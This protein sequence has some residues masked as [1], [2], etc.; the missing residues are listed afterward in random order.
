MGRFTN[1]SPPV[2]KIFTANT[3]QQQ[4][5]L[6][7]WIGAR[8]VNNFQDYYCGFLVHPQTSC[9]ASCI[10]N[11]QLRKDVGCM[12]VAA[13]MG[14]RLSLSRAPVLIEKSWSR[15][16]LVPVRDLAVV[17]TERRQIKI[18]ARTRSLMR[19]SQDC[20]KLAGRLEFE[21]RQADAAREITFTRHKAELTQHMTCTLLL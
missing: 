17:P 21:R 19:P 18:T 9:C 12:G 11:C 1:T 4:L 6:S 20:A 3:L 10:C 13:A 5:N 16:L 14:N 2:C 8:M 15:V 7:S